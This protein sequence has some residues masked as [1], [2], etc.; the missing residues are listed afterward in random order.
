MRK[1]R[2]YMNPNMTKNLEY[3]PMSDAIKPLAIPA[4]SN[5]KVWVRSKVQ[6]YNTVDY[7]LYMYHK[8]KKNLI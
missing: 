2:V 8:I 4:F 6:F 5:V 1:K 3:L 7:F